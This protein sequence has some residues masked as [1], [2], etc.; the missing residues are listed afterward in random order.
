MF[1]TLIKHRFLTYLYFNTY[2]STTGL[3]TAVALQFNTY[4]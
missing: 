4:I 1:Y 2:S 3:W